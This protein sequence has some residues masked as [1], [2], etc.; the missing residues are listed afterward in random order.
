MQSGTFDLR[1]HVQDGL[2]TDGTV[3]IA[4]RWE[5]RGVTVSSAPDHGLYD[6]V[7]RAAEIVHPDEIMT[8]LGADDVLM[9]GA[10]ATVASIFDQLPI[11]WVTGLPFVGNDAIGNF[12]PGKPIPFIRR[13]LVA[14]LHDGRSRGFVMQEGTFWRADLWRKVGGLDRR[15]EYAADWD[16]WRRLAQ[17]APLFA[18]TFPL[19]RFTKRVGQTSDNMEAYY[20]EID[21]S[22]PLPPVEDTISYRL[23]RGHDEINWII[24]S[25]DF[26]TYKE[27]DSSEPL[28]A[29][30]D[31]LLYRLLRR[32]DK[33]HW[34]IGISDF[35]AEGMTT[36]AYLREQFKFLIIEALNISSRLKHSR[37]FRIAS[38]V[39]RSLDRRLTLL[40]SLLERMQAVLAKV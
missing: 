16:L 23:L 39:S 37:S 11:G 19:A 4:R 27:I 5:S 6:A 10:L 9:P 35:S 31:A 33:S 32:H 25:S 3:E 36:T 22:E 29:V 20:K 34:I 8:W 14:G 28:P 2:S 17:N 18:L 40:H 30:N 21:S 38:S 13:D 24:E 26:S 15:F 1:V 7:N 12:T